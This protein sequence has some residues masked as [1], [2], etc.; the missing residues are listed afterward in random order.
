MSYS[1]FAIY[2]VPPEGALADFG[3]R[4]LGWDLVSGRAVDQP[5]LP[6]LD[7]ISAAPQKYGFHGTLKTPFRLLEGCGPDRLAAAVETMAVS[8]APATCDG[9]QLSRLGRFLALTPKGDSEGIARIAATCVREPD[10]LRAPVTE[11]ELARRRRSR[12]SA[13]QDKMLV[14]WGYPHVMDEFRFHMTLTGRLSPDQVDRWQ[15][16]LAEH[17]PALPEPFVMDAIALV[18]ER[19][20]GRF[21]MI[22]RYALTG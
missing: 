2:F 17:L 20:D 7:G 18:G 9:L 15:G 10:S 22:Q 13:R 19:A 1:R 5:H 12:L 14:R 21:E 16:I 11:V 4:W 3:A 6:G 8:C